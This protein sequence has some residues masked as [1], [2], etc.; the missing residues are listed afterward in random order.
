MTKIY[1]SIIILLSILYRGIFLPINKNVNINFLF[2][3]NWIFIGVF[4]MFL[5]LVKAPGYIIGGIYKTI[6]R[7]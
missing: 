6:L 7:Q 5:D 2:P 4:G 1:I 3:F